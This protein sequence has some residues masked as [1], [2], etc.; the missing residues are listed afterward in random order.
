MALRRLA[1]GATYKEQSGLLTVPI[2]RGA[3]P[4]AVLTD[5]LRELFE[6]ADH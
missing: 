6:P 1:S 5:L 2:K 4:T 3:N